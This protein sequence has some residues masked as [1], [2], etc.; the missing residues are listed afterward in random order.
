MNICISLFIVII[1]LAYLGQSS[2]KKHL[3]FQLLSSASLTLKIHI[4][5]SNILHL[6]LPMIS[7]DCL[8]KNGSTFMM[9]FSSYQSFKKT[10][11]QHVLMWKFGIYIYTYKPSPN[12]WVLGRSQN[13]GGLHIIWS[14]DLEKVRH[15]PRFMTRSTR[16]NGKALLILCNWE[17]VE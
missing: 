15:A 7:N 12:I 5:V 14:V 1:K 2:T 9:E 13:P 10:F 17:A 16:V 11:K 4:F 8:S 3:Q 6:D